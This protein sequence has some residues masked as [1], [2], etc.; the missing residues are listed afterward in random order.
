MEINDAMI[1]IRFFFLFRTFY[2]RRNNES[3]FRT[4][5]SHRRLYVVHVSLFFLLACIRKHTV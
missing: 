3:E 1:I 4:R 5:A 2:Y